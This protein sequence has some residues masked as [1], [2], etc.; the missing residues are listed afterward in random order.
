MRRV[1]I[2]AYCFPPDLAAGALRP[3]GLYRHLSDQGWT[4]TILTASVGEELPDVIRVPHRRVRDH[5]PSVMD[6]GRH[7]PRFVTIASRGVRRLVAEV[8]AHPDTE[9]GWRQSAVDCGFI[10]ILK[11]R[12]L[13]RTQTARRL[14]IQT[15]NLMKRQ[16]EPSIIMRLEEHSQ[17]IC[18]A[19]QRR[20]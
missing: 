19:R 11:Q 7:A 17:L 15:N 6:L 9:A 13:K 4:P 5:L 3:W 10:Q 8:A 20:L 16:C 2:I 18:S 14:I 12:R 1:L